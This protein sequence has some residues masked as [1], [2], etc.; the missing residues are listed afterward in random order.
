MPVE[1][2][3]G[4]GAMTTEE[5]AK[6]EAMGKVPA[7]E[8]VDRIAEAKPLI[9]LK[10]DIIYYKEKPADQAKCKR[11]VKLLRTSLLVV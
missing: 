8:D 7:I 11:L 6:L 3:Y 10:G 2:A 4:A 1:L 9:E 5:T